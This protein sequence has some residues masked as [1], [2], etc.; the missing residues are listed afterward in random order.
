MGYKT[1]STQG[2]LL[3]FVAPTPNTANESKNR[4]GNGK[5]MAGVK[6]GLTVLQQH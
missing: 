1:T 5:K 6:E 2:W 4:Q 3:L